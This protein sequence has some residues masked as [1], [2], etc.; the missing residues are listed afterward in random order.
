MQ[1]LYAS[2]LILYGVKRDTL[3]TAHSF[4]LIGLYRR[5]VLYVHR[6]PQVDLGTSF[7]VIKIIQSTPR[8]NTRVQFMVPL[9]SNTK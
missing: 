5:I 7:G 2:V 8:K 3:H 4:V 6:K 9:K 1:V